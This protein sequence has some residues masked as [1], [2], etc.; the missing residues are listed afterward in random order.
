MVG[1]ELGTDLA[2]QATQAAFEVTGFGLQQCCAHKLAVG[3]DQRG[4]HLAAACC[5]KPEHRTL[6]T[7]A[8]QSKINLLPCIAQGFGFGGALQR[9]ACLLHKAWHAL[10]AC[11]VHEC[12]HVLVA[13]LRREATELFGQASQFGLRPFK[14]HQDG[15]RAFTAA[16]LQVLRRWHG[17]KRGT[18]THQGLEWLGFD[19]LLVGCGDCQHG[20]LAERRA[21]G[22]SGSEIRARLCQVSIQA[23]RR[24]GFAC[25]GCSFF[26]LAL[27][28]SRGRNRC[29]RTWRGRAQ[30]KAD[31]LEFTFVFGLIKCLDQI[32]APSFF[33][34][35][36]QVLK[37]ALKASTKADFFA[38]NLECKRVWEQTCQHWIRSTKPKRVFPAFECVAEVGVRRGTKPERFCSTLFSAA[39][40]SRCHSAKILSELREFGHVETPRLE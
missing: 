38:E 27:A 8:V 19:A 39:N 29:S 25:L 40:L 21:Q 13:L 5:A 17:R 35:P 22:R 14:A 33:T 9:S 20:V 10:F 3:I 24:L 30:C 18:P 2:E 32:G 4:L 6:M 26:A 28:L 11:E 34:S 31:V 1:D 23:F 16:H 12:L 7:A 36:A 15:V 37:T